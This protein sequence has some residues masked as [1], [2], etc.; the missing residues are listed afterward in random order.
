MN[1]IHFENF[2]SAQV[3]EMTI[4]LTGCSS[5]L[6]RA[7]AER[8]ADAGHVVAGCA[9]RQDRIDS[10][11]E[12]FPEP[13][14]F[15]VCDVS[16][17]EDAFDFCKEAHAVTGVPDLVINN[18]AIINPSAP[19]WEIPAE[20]FDRLMSVNISGTANIIRHAVPFMLAAG[21]G[22]I[23][24]FSSGWGRSTSPEVAPYCA[25]KWGIE[26]LTQALAQEL[27]DGLAAVALNP[28]V[29]DTAML[30]SCFGDGAEACRTPAE[31]AESAVPFLLSLG[32]KDN[33]C[34]LTAP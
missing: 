29:I 8:F 17:D 5:G 31:W 27:P 13:N 23:V 11:K 4:W 20:D 16:S 9:R 30:R 21:K 24:N 22:V 1:G 28:G 34:S 15:K 2:V 33:G 18:A 12:A 19:L 6:G 10:L 26:G 7:L 25:S 32:A 14:F 3:L